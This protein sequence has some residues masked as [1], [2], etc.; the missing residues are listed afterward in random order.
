MGW[1]NGGG[2][3]GN[4]GWAVHGT[5]GL[6]RSKS[7]RH[8]RFRWVK[9][10]GVIGIAIL[11]ALLLIVAVEAFRYVRIYNDL[12]EGKDLLV[13]AADLMEQEGL[14]IA[15]DDLGEAAQ[16]FES[17]R[18]K[19]A[20]ASDALG[21]DP[22]VLATSRLPWIGDQ[23]NAAK[24]VTAI[25]VTASDMG[26]EAAAAMRTYQG[27][28][29][30]QGGALSERVVPVLEAVEPNVVVIEEK[31]A[32]VQETRAGI[33]DDGLLGPLSSAVDQL[34]DHIEELETSLA[35]YRRAARM[36]PKVLGYDGPQTY[37]VLAHDNTEMLGTGGFILVYGFI[38]FD[39]GRLE[40]LFFDDVG[41][42]NPTWPPATNGYIDPP[43]PLQ[44]YLLGDWPMGLA[45]ASWWPDFPTAAQNAIEIYHTNSGT[46]E[47]IDG[48]IGVNF[49]TLEKLMEVVGPIT[50]EKYDVTVS[51]QDVTDKTLI[52][53][54][55]EGTRPWETD[56]YDFVGYLAKE[57]IDS[58]LSSDASK[59]APMSSALRTLGREK[60]L[61]LYHTDPSVQDVIA[62]FGWDGGLKGAGGDYLMVVDSSLRSTKL[63]LVVEPR[64]DLDVS[65]DREGNA[66]DVVTV[67][68]ANDYSTWSQGKDP[69]LA[70][71]VTGHGS[72][73]LYGDYLRLVVPDGTS[74]REV[75]EEGTPVGAEDTWSEGGKAVLA[76]YFV[77]PLDAKKELAFTYAVPLVVEV[78]EDSHEYRLFVQKQPGTRAIPLTITIDPPPG[79]KII[80]TELDG[81]ELEGKPNRIVTDLREDRE[82]VVRYGPR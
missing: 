33:A 82:V 29:D 44:T 20:S 31:L 81:E 66:T 58:A 37:L 46:Q 11:V 40:R 75:A 34:D 59:W 48:V 70:A 13:G 36:A 77:L 35:D 3:R 26:M 74:L 56:R 38:V 45:E 43:R 18:G 51:S 39:E 78:S 32:N 24:D 21:S 64:I 47:P 62:D 12:A 79:W 76:R 53:T 30:A 49:L 9:S 28:R 54:H 7:V 17:G 6:W 5:S 19:F 68:Y 65:I 14:D 55:P 15:G 4:E 60:N 27:I 42:I 22:F 73:P 80:S 71:L 61:L 2:N 10:R 8:S 57:V 25:G 1:G 72:L 63:N 50:V 23:V 16:R 67:T 69:H 52:I 41:S